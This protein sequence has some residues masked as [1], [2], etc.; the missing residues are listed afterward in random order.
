MLGAPSWT[1][2]AVTPHIA[3]ACWWHL[4]YRLTDAP[5]AESESPPPLIWEAAGRGCMVNF[6]VGSTPLAYHLLVKGMGEQGCYGYRHSVWGLHFPGRTYRVCSCW[7]SRSMAGQWG[8][9]SWLLGSHCCHRRTVLP[10]TRCLRLC[11][12]FSQT[13]HCRIGFCCHTQPGIVSKL[14]TELGR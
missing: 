9:K 13:G 12:G 14:T 3:V 8:C 7:P 2:D 5:W 10:D 11:A 4:Q 1:A 6:L